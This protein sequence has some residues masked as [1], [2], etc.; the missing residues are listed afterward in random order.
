MGVYDVTATGLRAVRQSE[1]REFLVGLWH[2]AHGDSTPTASD[3]PD[4][5]IIDTLTIGMTAL[6]EGGQ[7]VYGS[8]F[9]RTSTG[10]SLEQ[11]LAMF[12]REKIPAAPS[13]VPLVF[14]GTTGVTV[15]ALT[16]TETE[17]Q[18]ATFRSTIDAD[19][20][21]T[22]IVAKVNAVSLGTYTLDVDTGAQTAVYIPFPGDTIEFVVGVLLTQLTNPAYENLY[23]GIQPDG[24][25]LIV[26]RKLDGSSLSAVFTAFSPTD[27]DVHD[28]VTV[29][30]R[31]L[32]NG[33]TEAL[34]GTVNTI[35]TGVGG[36]VGVATTEDATLG[37]DRETDTEFRIRHLER[38][39]SNGC[40]TREA[41]EDGIAENVDG[42][43]FVKVRNNR[44]DLTDGNGLPPHSVEAI[45]DGGADADVAA[46]I[47]RCLSA[48]IQPHGNTTTVIVDREGVSQSIDYSRPVLRYLH[49]RITI[50][51]GEGFPTSGDP[52]AAIV[53]ALV[54]FYET[55]LGKLAPGRDM[56]RFQVSDPIASAVPGIQSALIESDD[57]PLP[58][59]SPT[60]ADVDLAVDDLEKL[61][62]DS[63]RITVII[64]P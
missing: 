27:V 31:E 60:F 15:P 62:A 28:A 36:I 22:L 21:D 63:S 56:V 4:G 42:V 34:S 43:E 17:A 57:T 41:I 50:T 39:N 26:I 52:G 3:T 58:G 29:T 5:L 55:G 20:A 48:G 25:G 6:L 9:F 12:G 51:K 46:E 18:T 32:Q 47:F 7:S 23:G 61:V 2:G 49:H 13:T 38:L 35:T 59:D 11:L 53:S 54:A 24:S 40:G 19:T 8:G 16:T 33:P 1:V 45:V 10:V 37:R 44:T 14:F 64:T 30:G